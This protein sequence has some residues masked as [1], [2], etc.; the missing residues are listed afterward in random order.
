M[1]KKRTKPEKYSAEQVERYLQTYLQHK[2][3]LEPV[4]ATGIARWCNEVLHLEPPLSYTDLTRKPEIKAKITR[5]N[6]NLLHCITNT[7]DNIVSQSFSLIDIESVIR[8][9]AGPE[10]IRRVLQKANSMI[11]ELIE[12]NR[13][14]ARDRQKD[15]QMLQTMQVEN[16]SLLRNTDQIRAAMREQKKQAWESSREI[17]RL[18]RIIKKQQEYIEA[19]VYDPISA[20]HFMDM[21][22]EN[23]SSQEPIP[24]GYDSLMM[25]GE[26]IGIAITD[27]HNKPIIPEVNVVSKKTSDLMEQLSSL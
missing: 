20:D 13:K 26:D 11:E 12:E 4:S 1:R 22:L 23:E 2:D 7:S 25:Q 21:G 9:S 5:Y 6:E 19:H 16:E 27:V 18:K 17:H 24:K 10:G 8:K 3:T 14:L 15:R